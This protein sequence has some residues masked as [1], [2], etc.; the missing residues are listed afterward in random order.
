MEVFLATLFSH[1]ELSVVNQESRLL[2]NLRKSEFPKVAPF[3]LPP[4]LYRVQ[5][6]SAVEWEKGLTPPHEE[7]K[8]VKI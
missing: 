7:R 8:S 1:I 4:Q 5:Y 6:S 2:G 3:H